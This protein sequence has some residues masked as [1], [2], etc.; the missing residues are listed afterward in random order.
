MQPSVGCAQCSVAILAITCLMVV[1]VAS[2]VVE[3]DNVPTEPP[4]ET[5]PTVIVIVTV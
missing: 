4:A 3:P 1:S 5:T 2:V